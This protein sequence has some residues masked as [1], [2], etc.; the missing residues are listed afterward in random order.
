M[1]MKEM[2]GLVVVSQ[3]VN[4]KL[5]PLKRAGGVISLLSIT[6]SC[7]AI[8]TRGPHS[9]W[10]VV[11]LARFHQKLISGKH[12][13]GCSIEELSIWR[14]M[15]IPAF[16]K[17]KHLIFSFQFPCNMLFSKSYV[18]WTVYHCDSSRIKDQLHVTCYFI[19]L[20]M[21]STCFG[22]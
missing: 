16:S 20:L 19:S 12:A 14:I 18:Y 2:N 21:C 6:N 8:R 5:N 15:D 10:K 13:L 17:T 7:T 1:S 9:T 3:S 22:H 11:C 4:Q